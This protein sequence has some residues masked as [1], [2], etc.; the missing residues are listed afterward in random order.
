[1]TTH[2]T[3]HLRPDDQLEPTGRADPGTARPAHRLRAAVAAGPR[4]WRQLTSM[5]VALILLFLLAL[6]SLPGALLPQWT[7]DAGRTA[8]FIVDN[9]T[10]GPDPG[11]AGLLRGLRLAL[12]RGH[13]PGPVHLAD[14]LPGP[15]HLGLRPGAA[16]QAGRDPAQPRP[17]AARTPPRSATAEAPEDGRGPHRGRS[18]RLAARPA[19]TSRR[20]VDRLGREG[21]PARGRQPGL[22]LLAARPA[23]R[24]RGGQDVRLRGHRD[25]HRGRRVLLQLAERLQRVPARAADRRHRPRAVLRQPATASTRSTPTPGWPPTSTPPSGTRPVPRWPPGRPTFTPTHLRVN[26]PLRINGERLYLLGHGFSPIFEVTFPNG[27]VRTASQTFQP[28]DTALLSEGVVKFLDPPGYTGDEVPHPPAGAA[29]AVRPDRGRRPRQ[30]RDPDLDRQP[31][32]TTRRWPSRPGAG[33]LG[34]E[35]GAEPVDLRARPAPGR[36]R[37]AGEAGP[38]EPEAGRVLHAG[39]RHPGHLHRLPAVGAAADVLRPGAGLRPGVRDHPA[40]RADAVADREAPPGLVPHHSR[41]RFRRQYRRGGG[42][43][44]TDQAGYGEEFTSL[45]ALARPRAAQPES[46][47]PDRTHRDHAVPERHHRWPSAVRSARS[48]TRRSGPP[49][50]PTPWR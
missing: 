32:R 21:L 14:R 31:P 50:P 43:A 29:G 8:Q 25:R 13:L 6:A 4:L 20:R 2:D 23:G 7:L 35:D 36:Q 47:V 33:D 34:M 11:P 3:T 46:T 40:G 15:A 37:S 9:P 12:V 38:G 41:R 30:R 48:P 1:M 16:G 49:P 26:E 5:R 19:G 39:R 42:L 18:A 24:D 22:P 27:E 44:R 45:A 10:L 28:T 17:A